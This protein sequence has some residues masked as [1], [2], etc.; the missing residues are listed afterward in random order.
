VKAFIPAWERH[1]KLLKSAAVSITI[2]TLG[3][4]RQFIVTPSVRH[5]ILF[6]NGASGGGHKYGHGGG[7]SE[8]PQNWSDD[9]IIDRVES[10]ANDPL[11]TSVSGRHGRV[12]MIGLRNLVS[13][14]VVVDRSLNFVYTGFPT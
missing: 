7:K 12:I 14:S 1:Q 9:E 6:G 2:G 11:S 8:F 13:I 10:V 3:V 4:A 5:H